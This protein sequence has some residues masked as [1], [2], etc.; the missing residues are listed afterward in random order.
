MAEWNMDTA[1]NKRI[2]DSTV[3]FFD[4]PYIKSKNARQDV[5][6]G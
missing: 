5:F 1:K 6:G 2:A 4:T 3:I